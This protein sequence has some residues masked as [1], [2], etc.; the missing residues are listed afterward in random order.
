MTTNRRPRVTIGVPV[1]NAAS[2]L[3]TALDSLLAQSYSAFELIIS[4]NASTDDTEQLCREYAQ[5]DPRIRYI[6]HSINRGGPWN[7]NH[8]FEVSNTE[9]FKWAAHDDVCHPTYLARCIEVLDRDSEVAWCHTFSR[10]IDVEGNLLLGPDT[11]VVSYINGCQGRDEDG[12]VRWTR[13]D[14]RPADRFCAV[15]LG[16]G[17][18]LDSYGVIRSD[19]LRKTPLYLP[20]FG[21]EK[22]L[23]A[24]LGLWGRYH[25]I[26][27]VLFFARIHPDA[28]GNQKTA[29]LQ[30]QFVNPLA[31]NSARLARW[32]VLREYRAAVRRSKISF[33]ERQRCYFGLMRYLFQVQK[34]KSVIMK[35]LTGAGLAGEYPAVMTN[36]S[37]AKACST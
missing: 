5:R 37:A 4:D 27:E 20:Y 31:R 6:R 17:G 19:V 35:A 29:E 14:D 7:F 36:P 32:K 22:V 28:A 16:R 18:C 2:M 21:S 1:Y 33:W 10:H 25:E 9:Y 34:W 23:M 8:V 13:A 12:L 3:R 15:L 24:E 11:P 26:P 30:Q